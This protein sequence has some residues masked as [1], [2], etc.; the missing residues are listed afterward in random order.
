[1]EVIEAVCEQPL[2]SAIVG[3][4]RFLRGGGAIMAHLRR[5]LIIN[6]K[7]EGW[8]R[9]VG[10]NW[11]VGGRGWCLLEAER[12]IGPRPNKAVGV[13]SDVGMGYDGPLLFLH[14]KLE[15]YGYRVM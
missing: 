15:Y 14:L 8:D 7:L 9:M 13:G 11:G 5:W 1:M 2:N 12:K 3:L 10:K 6:E 4:T